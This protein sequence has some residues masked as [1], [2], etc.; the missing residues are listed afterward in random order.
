M[1]QKKA[2]REVGRRTEAMSNCGKSKLLAAAKPQVYVQFADFV[3]FMIIII[4]SP[5]TM[6]DP[7]PM[8]GPTSMVNSKSIEDPTPRNVNSIMSIAIAFNAGL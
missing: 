8:V 2:S 7:T 1:H 6:V 3:T 5:S 4:T